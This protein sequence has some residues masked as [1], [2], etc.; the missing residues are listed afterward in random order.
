MTF[1]HA[2]VELL[3]TLWVIGNYSCRNK[4]SFKEEISLLKS[5][6]SCI[7]SFSYFKVQEVSILF[8]I[9]SSYL[10]ENPKIKCCA[11][12][13]LAEAKFEYEQNVHLICMQ[14]TFIL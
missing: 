3:I 7:C 12:W 5:F 1:P 14:F 13:L 2:I 10:V 4:R 9:L 8:V 6:Q 11:G